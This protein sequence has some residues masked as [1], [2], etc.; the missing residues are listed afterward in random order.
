VVDII[1]RTSLDKPEK[2]WHK[3]EHRTRI[4]WDEL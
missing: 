1:E 4:C 3:V 2:S